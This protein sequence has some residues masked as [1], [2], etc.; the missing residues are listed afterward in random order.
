MFQ[1]RRHHGQHPHGIDVVGV[2]FQRL[3]VE[4]FR[5]LELAFPV[6]PGG[7]RQQFALG[8]QSERRFERLVRR[9]ALAG[10]CQRLAQV[11]MG[12]LQFRVQPHRFLQDLD[13]LV[14]P[15]QFQQYE[16][17][18]FVGLGKRRRQADSAL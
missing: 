12:K 9:F 15:F 18:V 3:A 4:F 5:F 14:V 11:E 13:R 1:R 6:Q 2:V 10:E 8:G 17:Q 16:T 7:L